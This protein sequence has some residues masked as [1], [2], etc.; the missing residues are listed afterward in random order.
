[1]EEMLTRELVRLGYGLVGE[2]A[3]K[4]LEELEAEMRALYPGTGQN[5]S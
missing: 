4:K 2:A 1:M 5:V 3:E